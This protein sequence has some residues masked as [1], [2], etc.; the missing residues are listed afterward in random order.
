[1]QLGTGVCRLA[2]EVEKVWRFDRG[3]LLIGRFM[4]FVLVGRSVVKP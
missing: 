2:I 4:E 1:M 3:R